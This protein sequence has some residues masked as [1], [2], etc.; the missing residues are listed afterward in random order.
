MRLKPLALGLVSLSAL[1]AVYGGLASSGSTSAV[2]QYTFTVNTTQ[3]T[4]DANPGDGKCEDASGNCSLRAAVMEANALKSPAIINIPPGTY[5]LSRE[6]PIDEQGGSLDLK[7]PI[8]LRG[9]G[10]SPAD[11]V[12]T[13]TNAAR[14]VEI[15]SYQTATLGNL[16][17]AGAK[18]SS[19]YDAVIYNRGMV[20]L[21]NVIIRDGARDGFD[22]YGTATLTSVTIRGNGVIGFQNVGTATLTDVTIRGNGLMGFGNLGTATLTGVTIQSNNR[23]GFANGQPAAATLTSVIIQGNGDLG[24]YNVGTAT[25]TRVTIQGNGST[26]FLN[27]GG[28]ATLL[29]TTISG[30][31]DGGVFNRGA[32]TLLNTTVSGNI[33]K[34]GGGGVYNEG[35]TLN[36]LF[37]TI[38]GNIAFLG[39][40]LGT[41]SGTVRL[42]GVILANNAS[43][44]GIG[45]D[46]AGSLQSLGYNLIK[47]IQDCS[48]TPD[49]TDILN[50]DPGLEPLRDNGGMVPTH[51]PRPGS[52]VLDRVPSSACTDLDGNPI[53]EDARGVRR[54]RGSAC[55]IGAVE[56]E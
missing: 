34:W 24:F 22:N 39:G 5:T 56:R 10:G 32:L 48:F 7:A 50:R 29:Q 11:T 33:H 49:R 19:D 26:G 12:I 55:D 2:S 36:I 46:C 45:P 37:S 4:I 17:L 51:M 30:N 16:T 31:R 43:M 28:T 42:E 40:G 35:G 1:F 21:N 13:T 18:G 38:T 44:S 25:L 47:N 6:S 14:L 52:P 23:V 41:G 8:T 27:F 9:Q 15:H 54:P 20:T 53:R 3:D